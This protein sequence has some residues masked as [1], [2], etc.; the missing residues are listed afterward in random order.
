M[1]DAALSV[2]G[3]AVKGGKILIGS[4]EQIERL[5]EALIP[6]KELTEE[7]IKYLEEP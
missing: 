1:L 3:P 4:L 7:E 5:E 2:V 6:D